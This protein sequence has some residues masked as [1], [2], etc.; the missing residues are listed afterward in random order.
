MKVIQ[1][2]VYEG[3]NIY[4]PVPVVRWRIDL[5]ELE[6]WPTGRLG[7]A[8]TD[9]LLDRLPGMGGQ[10]GSEGALGD[11]A[12]TMVEKD[13]VSL[14]QV[15][16]H[17]AIE[18]QRLGGADIEFAEARP[19]GAAG[20]YDVLYGYEEAEVG[21]AA[22]Q[23]ALTLIGHLLPSELRSEAGVPPGFDF[24]GA[25]DAFIRYARVR[26]FSVFMSPLVKAAKERDIPWTRV[27][28]YTGFVMLGHGRFRQCL[29]ETMTGDASHVAC[30][31]SREKTLTN[32]ILGRLGLP[33]P[34]Q[35][36]VTSEKQAV[37]EADQI[38]YPV[39]VKPTNSHKAHGVS[40][41]LAD[42]QAVS[43]AYKYARKHGNLVI[44]ES[45]IEGDVHRLLVVDG[46]LIAAAKSVPPQVIGDGAHT[47]ENLVEEL[48][49]DPR[50]VLED[51]RN[52]MGRLEFD[53]QVERKLA[54]IG[55]TRETVPEKGETVRL[56]YIPSYKHGSTIIDMTDRVHPDN[57]VM[58]V[59]ATEAI[60]LVT[61]GIDFIISDISRS[62]KDV[63]GAICEVNCA[64]GLLVHLVAEG[65]PRDVAGP[66]IET[67]YA[68]GTTGRIPITAVTGGAGATDA[69]RMLAHIL[70]T[71]GQIVGLATREG[72]VVD[73][74][75]LVR[76]NMTGS[77]AARSVLGNPSVDA[78]VLET[79][80]EDVLRHG[81]G[82]DFCDVAA[83]LDASAPPRDPDS[84]APVEMRTKAMEVIV[85]AARGTVV[86][87]ADDKLCRTMVNQAEAGHVCYVTRDSG[88]TQLDEHLA[89][90][91]RAVVIEKG[92]GGGTI[93][94]RDGDG[95][96]AVVATDRI[97][98]IRD[99]RYDSLSVMFAAAMAHALGKSADEIREGLCAFKPTGRRL[100]Q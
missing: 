94:I 70:V 32:H 53:E 66:I 10:D 69:A 72:I 47:I 50:R 67:L 57:R 78:A 21:I 58:A 68:P 54:E 86:L 37:S 36:L 60:G 1:T 39:V 55:Y 77:F 85:R 16:G 99:K 17:T 33:V 48:N 84:T 26:F 91:G 76:G 42:A 83:V 14:S 29:V 41:R 12:R 30:F 100:P 40:I 73:G 93:T 98:A 49:R 56:R 51:W 65:E 44:V 63:G 22:G 90:G 96:T 43:T 75:A 7:P 24:A 46:E 82:F 38:G 25:R 97:P 3:P 95:R 27:A 4:V 80:P 35:R 28:R 71:T 52:P 89:A 6:E 23:L 34:R 9:A 8:F 61:S 13:G 87:N 18:L 79:S 15:L 92:E 5:G 81:L 2:A 88:H 20:I 59:R 31:I 11:F 64:P 62:Y 74:E 19:T 45:F